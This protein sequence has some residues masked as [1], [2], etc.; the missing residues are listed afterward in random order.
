MMLNDWEGQIANLLQ[1]RVMRYPQIIQSLMFLTG[2]KRDQ[3]CLPRTNK[4]SWKIVRE[5]QAKQ[6]SKAMFAYSMFG[7]TKGRD[8]LPY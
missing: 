8:V 1:Y 6:F 3:V 7:E 2:F 5:M 4:L